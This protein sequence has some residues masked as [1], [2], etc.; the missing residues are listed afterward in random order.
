LTIRRTAVVALISLAGG[1]AFLRVLLPWALSARV[2][3]VT[4]LG[5][6]F[7][8]VAAWLCLRWSFIPQLAMLAADAPLECFRASWRLTEG[9]M[10]RVSGLAAS[11]AA[12]DQLLHGLAWGLHLVGAIDVPSDRLLGALD[13]MME[14]VHVAVFT[15]AYFQVTS[16]PPSDGH[17]RALFDKD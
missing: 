7:I 8:F 11:I 14:P 3:A 6:P 16:P 5:V 17:D 15:A 10:W 12:V 9:R 13:S 4:Y 2:P 1:A